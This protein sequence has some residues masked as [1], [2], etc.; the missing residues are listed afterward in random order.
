MP[1]IMKRK[2]KVVQEFPDHVDASRPYG[3]FATWNQLVEFQK[4]EKPGDTFVFWDIHGK[5]VTLDYPKEPI[6]IMSGTVSQF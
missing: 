5:K 4:F 2:S 6:L 3:P 1:G